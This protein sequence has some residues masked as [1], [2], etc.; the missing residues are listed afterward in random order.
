MAASYADLSDD[1]MVCNKFQKGVMSRYLMNFVVWR[2]MNCVNGFP[3]LCLK[4]VAKTVVNILKFLYYNI[5]C[6]ILSHLM[7]NGKPDRL[8]LTMLL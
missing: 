2:K 1:I 5:E 3:G 4:S 7:Q 6:G 8:F